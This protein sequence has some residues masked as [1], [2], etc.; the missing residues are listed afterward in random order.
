MPEV[1]GKIP[2]L[3]AE[4]GKAKITGVGAFPYIVSVEVELKEPAK[5][6]DWR[7]NWGDGLAINSDTFAIIG[8]IRNGPSVSVRKL[9]KNGDKKVAFSLWLQ[10]DTFRE[11][12]TV[13]PADLENA[14]RQMATQ[15]N[16][17]WYYHF[18]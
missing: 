16:K 2:Q 10:L 11:G 13:T 14:L 3:F 15:M 7:Q 9:P 4:A 5:V 6:I 18:K 1:A 12:D 17:T 8:A